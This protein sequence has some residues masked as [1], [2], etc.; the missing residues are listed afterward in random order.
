[1]ILGGG[2]ALE[3]FG[4]AAGAVVGAGAAAGGAAAGTPSAF[5]FSVTE[6]L[7]ASTRELNCSCV[8]PG[9]TATGAWAIVG[10]TD[11]SRR[12]APRTIERNADMDFP[13]NGKA[14]PA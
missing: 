14:S 8:M 7:M 4:A 13:L 5:S 9:G 10:A 1:M 12:L 6:L 3:D 2:G 11:R